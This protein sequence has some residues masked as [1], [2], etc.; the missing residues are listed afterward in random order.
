M[1]KIEITTCTRNVDDKYQAS[2]VTIDVV[3]DFKGA[4]LDTRDSREAVEMGMTLALMEFLGSVISMAG[5][6]ENEEL[7]TIKD[8]EEAVIYVT[9]AFLT[10]LQD[11]A[12]LYISQ[13]YGTAPP[14]QKASSEAP[15]D[16]NAMFRSLFDASES[17]EGEDDD[18]E[19]RS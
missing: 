10:R 12:G 9:E 11:A 15:T 8:F 6:G 3:R 1:F 7:D 18:K 13:V 5:P 17:G 16:W 19:P 2:G 4:I 14:A